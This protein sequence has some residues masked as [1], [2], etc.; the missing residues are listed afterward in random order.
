MIMKEVVISIL[1]TNLSNLAH[2]FMGFM[3][4]WTICFSGC[5][6]ILRGNKNVKLIFIY[7]ITAT[8]S[9]SHIPGF[10]YRL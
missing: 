4:M 10:I 6:Q 3:C 5:I 8:T 9:Q 2:K 7:V 1:I